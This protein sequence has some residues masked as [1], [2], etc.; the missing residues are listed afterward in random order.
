MFDFTYYNPVCIHFGKDALKHLASEIPTNKR[1]LLTYGG[2][3]IKRSG[4]YDNIKQILK[5]YTI[6]EF[7]G[8]E[9]NPKYETLMEAVKLIRENH[10][11]Y[12]LAVGGGSVI[13]GTKFIAAAYHFAGDP[14]DILEK[15]ATISEALPFGC[16]LTI[17]AAGSEYNCAAVISKASTQDKLHFITPLVFP[18]FAILDPKITFTLPE[19]QT[20]NGIVDIFVHVT[21]QYLTFNVN[22][23]L[24]D[25]FAEGILLTLIEEAPKVLADGQNYDTRA[26]IMWCSSIALNGLIGAGVPQDWATHMLGHELTAK[27]NLDHGQ[28]LAIILPSLLQVKRSQ[29]KDKLLQY[30][31]RVW[32]I[33]TGTVEEKIDLA[34]NKTRAFFESLGTQTRLSS[35]GI[36]ASDIPGIIQQL[37]KHNMTALGER[38]DID[39]KTSETILQASL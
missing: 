5:D 8:I 14:W 24:Q 37:Q 19:K 12:I 22:A 25:R 17:P 33:K 26:N 11:D 1:I 30:A 35:Y 38:E 7:G 21:E 2:G 6:F 31:E 27:F 32:N 10:I 36:T 23:A 16:V 13:D 18:Q 29:K 39:L 34:I 4:L 3:S 15:Q 20:A 9:P 28:T